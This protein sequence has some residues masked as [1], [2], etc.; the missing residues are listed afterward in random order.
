M[1]EADA[2]PLFG[3][4]TKMTAETRDT[5]KKTISAVSSA[6]LSPEAG[7]RVPTA[8]DEFTRKSLPPSG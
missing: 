7:R 4:T 8:R 6:M 3:H 5:S 1:N 2:F